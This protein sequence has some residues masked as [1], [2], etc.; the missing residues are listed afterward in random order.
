MFYGLVKL[1]F[2][3]LAIIPNGMFDAITTLYITG[4]SPCLQRTVVVEESYVCFPS[5]EHTVFEV[6]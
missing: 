3:I 2:N 5:V 4:G 6:I 1:R